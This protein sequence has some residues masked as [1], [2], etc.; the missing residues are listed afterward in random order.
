MTS[1]G[2][3]KLLNRVRNI[4]AGTRVFILGEG[5]EVHG[6]G[7]VSSEPASE[8]LRTAILKEDRPDRRLSVGDNIPLRVALRALDSF[9]Q[10]EKQVPLTSFGWTNDWKPVMAT[11]NWCP[12]D[13]LAEENLGGSG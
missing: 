9:L 4:E 8:V 2:N 12:E 1:S 11:L 13:D 10:F 7:I 6:L 5:G 3:E